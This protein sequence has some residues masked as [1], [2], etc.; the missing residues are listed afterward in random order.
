MNTSELLVLI[1]VFLVGY[2]TFKRCGCIE[3]IYGEGGFLD[4][5][6]TMNTLID[7]NIDK[8]NTKKTVCK[9]LT[10]DKV[11]GGCDENATNILKTQLTKVVNA[12]LNEG[13]KM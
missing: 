3:G 10:S 13:G 9:L 11:T 5:I 7:S 6:N 1:F 8:C 2:M 12:A 4:E